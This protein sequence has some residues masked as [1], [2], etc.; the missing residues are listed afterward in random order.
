M[1]A[2]T[3]CILVVGDEILAGHTLD[4]NS[5]WVASR[6]RD[7]GVRLER[8]EVV[9]DRPPEIVG[10]L[11]RLAARTPTFLFVLG[12]LGPTPDDR[13]YESVAQALGV[14]LLADPQHVA[15]LKARAAARG[16][17][18]SAWADPDRSEGMLRM[19]KIPQGAVALANPEGAALGCVANLGTTQVAVFPGV[20]RELKAMFDQSFVPTYLPGAR[21]SDVTEEL[22]VW[23]AEAELWEVLTGLE[24]EHPRVAIGSYPQDQRGRLILRVRGL[25]ADVAPVVDALRAAATR[26][27]SSRRPKA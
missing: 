24:R 9:P 19:V 4:T 11:R 26:L 2:P 13:T 17:G 3:A 14:P 25:P 16:F 7:L 1:T 6:L 20:P 18:A 27:E 12:G 15:Q 22:E 21:R 23:G 8:V 5:H 10:S